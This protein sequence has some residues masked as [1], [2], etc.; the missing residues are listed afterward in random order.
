MSPGLVAE[1][2][3]PGDGNK[4]PAVIRVHPAGQPAASALIQFEDGGG[5]VVAAFE[6]YIGAITVEQGRVV[7]V[8]YTPSRTNYRWDPGDADRLTALR[9]TVASAA[10]FGTFRIE[11][12]GQERANKA[13]R[14]ADNIRAFKAV[15]PSLGL[16]AVYAYAEAGIRE[17]IRSVHAIMRDDLRCNVFDVAMLAG[18]LTGTP[19]A[20]RR[21]VPVCP[22]LSQGWSWLR[23]RNVTLSKDV[24]RT[25][26]YLRPALWTTFDADG[27]LVIEGEIR[28]AV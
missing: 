22:M 8:N 14:L 19:D 4:R 3:E 13:A 15:D 16:Y 24:E 5:T 26:E 10:R 28:R 23:V 20:D 6:G 7:N 1:L 25:R 9:A 27:L 2:L 21:T 17:Q 18:A 11:G 12:S